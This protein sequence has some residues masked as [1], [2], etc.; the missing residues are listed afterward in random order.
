MRIK[1]MTISI[2][3]ITALF[4]SA[5]PDRSNKTQITPLPTAKAAEQTQPVFHRNEFYPGTETLASNEMR[6]TALGTGNPEPRRSQASA[7]FFVELGNG[8][9]FFFDIGTGSQANFPMLRVSY[10]A[11]SKVFLTHLHTDHAG[12]IAWLWIGGWVAG[13]F[14][15]PLEVWGPS[16]S[17][18]EFGTAYFIEMQK[19][20][21]KWDLAMR[22]GKLPAAGG[23]IEVHEFDFAKTHA[24]YEENGVKITS[25]PALH[26]MD[27]A[28]SYRL[29]WNGLSFVYSGDTTP[30]KF[31]VDNAQNADLLI[32]E[33]IDTLQRMVDIWGWDEQTATIVGSVI[34]TQPAAAGRV[35]SLT[36][37]RMAAGFHFFYD[38]ESAPLVYDA[39]RSTY[40]GPLTLLHDGIV[41]NVTP[42]DINVRTLVANE[43]TYPE[44]VGGDA[45]GRAKRLE[46][47]EPS[48][49]LMDNRLKFGS[50]E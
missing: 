28:V 3:L 48:S 47:T 10:R 12:D 24:V 50:D 14:D 18:R 7:S 30:T 27:G 2:A 17:T 20:A 39:I 29:D 23:A 44:T 8:D 16:G 41:F 37:P 5:N 25:F 4:L 1:I 33:S 43:N 9:N 11:A 46:N 38:R 34:H 49:W 32:H 31:F 6:V 35:F 26:G 45:Y 21:W 22:H 40:S 36:K 13:R 15:K 42:E 19:N